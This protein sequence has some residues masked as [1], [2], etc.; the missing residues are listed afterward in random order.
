VETEL[1]IGGKWVPAASGKRFDVLNPATGEVIA[2]VVKY[3][4]VSW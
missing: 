1:F 4:A 3:I 2:A